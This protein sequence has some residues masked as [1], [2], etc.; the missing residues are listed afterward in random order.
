MSASEQGSQHVI[1]AATTE[2][3]RSRLGRLSF[4]WSPAFRS[5]SFLP[6]GEVVYVVEGITGAYAAGR[7]SDSRPGYTVVSG[8]WSKNSY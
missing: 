5:V 4:L 8:N 7:V 3:Y 6:Q 1:L 2:I